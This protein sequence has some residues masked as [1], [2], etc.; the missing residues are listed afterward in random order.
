MPWILLLSLFLFPLTAE[1]VALKAEKKLL[2]LKSI[3]ADF[4][5]IYYSIS[6]STPL[7]EKGKFYFQKPDSMKWV[8]QK[9]EEKIFLYKKG[10]FLFYVPEDNQ[11]TRGLLSG[12]NHESEI[13]EL[14]SGKKVLRDNY[15]I[16]FSPFP[17]EKNHAFQLKLTPKEESEYSF[18][19][20][21]IDEKTWLIGKA[22]L[23]DW[24]GNRTEYRFSQIKTNVRLPQN[25]FELKVPPDVEIIEMSKS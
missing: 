21:E 4:E 22:I 6:V 1:D 25:I 5:Q 18:I 20:L 17:S 15:H 2:A 12:E 8:Y 14:F 24:T 13:L 11:L 9:P 23:F 16:E 7:R 19:L 10:K 3:K